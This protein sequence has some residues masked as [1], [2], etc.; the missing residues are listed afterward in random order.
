[1]DARE[2]LIEL[3]ESVRLLPYGRPSDRTVNAMLRELR[4]TCSTKHLYLA[5]TLAE[6]FPTV[7]PK[8]V[9]RVYRLDKTTAQHLFGTVVAD[10]VPADGLV[11]VH[12]Y[13]LITIEG[14]G[15]TIDVTFPGEPWDGRS[16][17]PL[18]CGPG[19]DIPAGDHP[20]RDKR[21]LEDDY[22]DP[23]VREP[24][25]TAL[26]MQPRNAQFTKSPRRRW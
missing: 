18:A 10:T 8:L 6:G 19:D 16:S 23:I 25:I 21:A 26:T 24:F 15:L 9:H 1:M 17:L 22:C 13:L 3:V 2:Q 11:D 4:G 7:E 14:K 12:R 5:Q 20:D